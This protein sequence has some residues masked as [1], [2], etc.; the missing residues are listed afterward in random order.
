M[1][2]SLRQAVEA[3]RRIF[4]P[5]AYIP[6]RQ[7]QNLRPVKLQAKPSPGQEHVSLSTKPENA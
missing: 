3:V 7:K 4:V 6:G 2:G 5:V 1:A